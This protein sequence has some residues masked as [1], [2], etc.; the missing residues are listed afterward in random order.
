[1]QMKIITTVK[2]SI[3]IF[4]S[5]SSLSLSFDLYFARKWRTCSDHVTL[6]IF[7]NDDPSGVAAFR[8]VRRAI[9]RKRPKRPIIRDQFGYTT[10]AVAVSIE[11]FLSPITLN[12]LLTHNP[13]IF[14]RRNRDDFCLDNNGLSRFL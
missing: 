4:Q 9:Q 11:S 5:N 1:M 8:L 13:R 6:E 2:D 3:I 14:G 12:A 10:D 7:K